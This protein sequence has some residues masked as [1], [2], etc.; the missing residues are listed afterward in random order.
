[1]SQ[2]YVTV[3]TNK[4]PWPDL[5]RVLVQSLRGAVVDV[6]GVNCEI[7]GLTN[8]RIDVEQTLD[9]HV[10][11]AKMLACATTGLDIAAY[12]DADSVATSR[13]GWLLEQA[14]TCEGLPLLPKHPTDPKNCGGVCA[15][16]SVYRQTTPYLHAS[17]IAFNESCR[18]FF[19]EVFEVAKDLHRRG[20][21]VPVGDETLVNVLTWKHGG[22]QYLPVIDPYYSVPNQTACTL[23]GC[24]DPD[25]A[26]KVLE[27]L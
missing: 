5:A 23:H 13:V 14:Q 9:H 4:D 17:V 12:I 10:W 1:M 8:R 6:V 21:L 7:P 19:W 25:Q 27:L 15:A 22:T 24:K 2:G 3:V 11:Y 26:R 18:A 20:I 16:L